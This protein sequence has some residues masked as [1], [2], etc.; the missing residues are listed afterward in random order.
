MSCPTCGAEADLLYNGQCEHCADGRTA[1]WI[2]RL[3]PE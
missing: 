2:E 1:E 3:Q